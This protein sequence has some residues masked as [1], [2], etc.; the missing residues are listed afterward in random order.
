M[1][2]RRKQLGYTLVE[3]AIA[4][5]MLVIVLSLSMRGFIHLLS[6]SSQQRVQN[7]LDI[8]VQTAMERIRQ[9]L[10]LTSLT[11]IFLSPSDGNTHKALSFP[12][13]RDDDG[14]GQVDLNADGKILWDRTLIYHVWGGSPNQLR[15]TIFD[16]RDNDL[17][18]EERQAQI[19]VVLAKG[20]GTSTHNGSSASTA[21]VFE[22]LFDWNVSP[23]PPMYDGYAPEMVRDINTSLGSCILSPGAHTL[24]FKVEDKNPQ[25]SG[26]KIGVDYVVASPSYSVRE[27]E[28]QLPVKSQYGA[29]ANALFMD[30]GSWSG[31]YQL[32]FPATA[33]GHGFSI[34][35]YN[36]LWEETNF[37][38]I[39]QTL[40]RTTVEFDKTLSPK[41]FVVELR[42]METNWFAHMQTADMTGTPLSSGEMVNTAMR[43]LVSGEDMAYGGWIS[44]EGERSRVNFR[45]G[46]AL[47]SPGGLVVSGATIAEANSTT[48]ITMDAIASTMTTLRFGGGD[49]HATIPAGTAIWSDYANLRIEKEKSYLVSFAT[50]TQAD[51]G[52]PWMWENTVT[53]N[54]P[55]CFV[56]PSNSTPTYAECSLANWSSRGDVIPTN[57]IY[58]VQA[59]YVTY[60][61]NG[62][63][64]STTFDTQ[65]DNPS[66]ATMDWNS[67][68]PGGTKI[69]MT[70]R[71]GSL[72]D[73][74]DATDWSSISPIG[75]PGP[76][77]PSS[78]RY[79][80]FQATLYADSSYFDTPKLRDV[81][82]DWPGDT[83][84][85]DV[86]GTFTKGPDFGVFQLLID[87]KPLQAGIQV[88]LEIFRDA[89]GYG[90][91]RRI[92][93]ALTTEVQP[94]NTWR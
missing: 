12:L 5:A 33:I 88:D 14:D 4:G 30:Q 67:A 57:K 76:I 13:A 69:M 17:S 19:D 15:L 24:T 3:V 77:S 52:D 53:T 25:S 65:K 85:I 66:Y 92:T 32:S 80:Q 90:G 86:G 42:G 8:D 43:I 79:V 26:Y 70:V 9:D 64:T 71:T 47:G 20:E 7:E 82:I 37:D 72:P 74:S 55:S 44:C 39:G 35:L 58:G 23:S 81:Q 83:R 62:T 18:E 41:D 59:L 31:N 50:T 89:R 36:D 46:R 87:G 1:T 6:G 63:Y 48:N 40:E 51:G 84:A 16:P 38:Q 61:T 78:S 91:A 22:N 10:R 2:L 29:V 34:N 94:L 60:P 27:A 56:I 21:I 54:A 73:M 75:S 45:A 68:L 93:S 11:E 28:A 49:L